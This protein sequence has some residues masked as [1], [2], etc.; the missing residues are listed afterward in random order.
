MKF[1]YIRYD[2]F[3][4][5]S[6]MF[7]SAG[8]G[9]GQQRPLFFFFATTSTTTAVPHAVLLL[10]LWLS[11]LGARFCVSFVVCIFVCVFFLVRYE[12]GK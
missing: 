7:C 4:S 11:V 9:G 8:L 2:I 10:L 12:K 3:K 6:I 5:A 1:L